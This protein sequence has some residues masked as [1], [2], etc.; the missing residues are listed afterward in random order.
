MHRPKALKSTLPDIRDE[1]KMGLLD[2]TNHASSSSSDV[3]SDGSRPLLEPD[4]SGRID[5]LQQPP[6]PQLLSAVGD[7]LPILKNYVSTVSW[8]ALL[9]RFAYFLVPSFLQGRAAREQ[10][11]RPSHKIAP[12]AYLDGIR[13]LAAL[14][15]FF[16]H[17]SY[18]CFIIAK[19]W[20]TDE[21]SLHF[22]KLP[23]IR[24]WY[25]GPAAVCVFF[26]ISGYA[27]S[28]KPLKLM[29]NHSFGDF[30]TTMSSLT[31][32]RAIR[33]YVPTAMS[34][35]MIVCCL[36]LGVYEWTRDFANDRTY[37]RNVLEPHPLRMESLYAQLVH[38]GW[39]MFRFFSVF[40]WDIYSGQPCKIAILCR[41]LVVICV[42]TF[43]AEQHTTFISGPYLSSS[44]VP[45]TYSSSYW[46]RP[47]CRQSSGILPWALS[48]SLCTTT[49]DGI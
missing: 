41:P 24:I 35:L 27:L 36:Q 23:L 37:M 2:E 40:N 44:A 9:G 15:V 32:R 4:A 26:V 17:Y 18:Q 6:H 5:L 47:G 22:L 25:Q 14:F 42:L 49:L 13:G 20:G 12:T 45:C 1:E 21:D 33:L 19:S 30:A 34:T 10:F 11:L 39:E 38:W 31:F 43:P 8:G 7:N 48:S 16:C 46:L 28:Y 29:R 3:E